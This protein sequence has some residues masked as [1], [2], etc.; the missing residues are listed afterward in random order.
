VILE[1]TAEF[2]GAGGEEAFSPDAD[3]LRPGDIRGPADARPAV[4]ARLCSASGPVGLMDVAIERAGEGSRLRHHEDLSIDPAAL[5]AYDDPEMALQIGRFRADGSYRAM[6][7]STDL[8]RGWVFPSLDEEALW[9]VLA[10]L[11]PAALQGWYQ[12]IMASPSL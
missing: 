5:E 2:S 10:R 3:F 12:G 11:Y 1:M 4:F 9:R 8:R 6:R 7:T